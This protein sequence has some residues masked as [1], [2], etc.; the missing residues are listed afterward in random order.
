MIGKPKHLTVRPG[1]SPQAA[2][3][4][5]AGYVQAERDE[6]KQTGY[7]SEKGGA[8]SRWLGEGAKRLGLEGP[9]DTKVFTELLQG[10]LP[11]GEDISARGGRQDSRRMGTDLT[12]SA[13]KSFSVFVVAADPETRAW[14]L[15]LWEECIDVAACI[16]E[17]EAIT[18]RRGKGGAAVEHTANMVAAAFR[19]E[20]ARPVAGTADM[21]VHTH[22]L[23]LNMTQRRD[24]QWVARDLDFGEQNVVRMIMD[25][26]AKAHLAKRLQERGYQL[27]QTKDGW[28]FAGITDEQIQLFSR[29]KEQVDTALESKG[30]TRESSTAAQR[31]A[32]NLATRGSKTTLSESE[33]RWEWRARVREAGIDLDRLTREA[34][35]RGPIRGADLS[36]EAVKSAARHLSERETVFSRAQTRLQ[37]LRAGMGHADLRGIDAAL[38]AGVGGLIDLGGKKYTTRD[39]LLA[40][41]SILQ[42]ARAGRGQV[43][44]LMSAEGAEKFIADREKQ[45]GFSFSPG[46][47][48]ALTLAL[49]APDHSA[50]IEGA[51]GAGKTTAMRAVVDAFRAGGF[52]I[53]GLAPIVQAAG[54]LRSAGA[55]DT[56]TMQSFLLQRVADPNTPRLVILDEA[57]RVS[58]DEMGRLQEKLAQM[59]GAR[60]LLTGDHR[61]ISSVEAGSPFEQLIE[62]G[63]IQSA[64]ITEVQRQKNPRLLEM[65][66][67]WADRDVPRAMQIARDFMHEV[68]VPTEHRNKHGELQ[69]TAQ[70]TRTALAAEA[71]ARYLDRDPER[72]ERTL[73]MCGLNEV[74]RGANEAIRAGLQARGD[75]SRDEL[76]LRALDK[77]D[78]SKEHRTLGERYEPGMVVRLDEGRGRERTVTDYAVVRI[79]AER[80]I[81]KDDAGKERTWSPHAADPKRMEV[82]QQR[83]MALAVGDEIQ[84]RANIGNRR[85]D[86][87]NALSNGQVGKVVELSE[88]GPRVE[89]DDGR[90]IAL[91]KDARH[92]IDYSYCRT[93]ARTQGAEKT[94]VLLVGEAGRVSTAQLA[95]VGLTRGIQALEVITDNRDRLA[96]AWQKTADRQCAIEAARAEHHPDLSRLSE[97]RAEAAHELGRHGDL[98]RARE[99]AREDAR[100]PIIE[101]GAEVVR[102]A[103]ITA[104]VPAAKPLVDVLARVHD[105]R[106]AAADNDTRP[107]P[108]HE[109]DDP[110]ARAMKEGL[111]GLAAANAARDAVQKEQE[112]SAQAAEKEGDAPAKAPAR[113]GRDRGEDLELGR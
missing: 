69:P 22:L 1:Q 55:D 23:A 5:V 76:K 71:A 21:D 54:Q 3:A 111:A 74:R 41:H 98:S 48:A 37:A 73:L 28:E 100:D 13:P 70:E 45:Q 39:A 109:R 2:A 92:C 33:Q 63:A 90:T 36:Y 66:Q 102:D 49:T 101:H 35:A 57:G 56:R 95:Y 89:M 42:A 94:E 81:L 86:P 103:A 7:Y 26:S 84:I 112:R 79:E 60:L 38:A 8:P 50:A 15:Q 10:H 83:E 75:I 96:A 52:E 72:R 14:A 61:Q 25:F 93:V 32:A 30:L 44:P 17:K 40:E 20:D 85:S 31:D 78:M 106:E 29:R 4:Q 91:A 67:A 47:R 58:R 110:K 18:A 82:Y 88:Q 104:L 77:V 99:D 53:V 87:E 65:A 80:V 59:P 105:A 43:Q 9:V 16:L 11:T 24:G 108:G 19:H 51:A 64:R 27:R 34:L 97:L 107:V 62:S 46:Q 12:I 6:G 113:S 68:R